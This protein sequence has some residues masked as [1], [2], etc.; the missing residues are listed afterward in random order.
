MVTKE[1]ID[2]MN[3]KIMVCPQCFE[4]KCNHGCDKIEIDESMEEILK[5]LNNKNY[6]TLYHCGGHVYGGFIQIYIMFA[7]CVNF[8]YNVAIDIGRD[9]TWDKDK[10][11]LECYIGQN[12]FIGMSINNRVHF[13]E[14]K[15]KELLDW[16]NSLH[17]IE[18]PGIYDFA[19]GWD[20][21]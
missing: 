2:F 17:P 19:S 13:L 4:R 9:W 5:V 10:N 11:M 3:H 18:V 15:H 12:R 8:G 14:S 1:E 20:E 7:S 21:F 16:A 6:K